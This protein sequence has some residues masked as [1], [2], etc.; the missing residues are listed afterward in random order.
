MC[1][2]TACRLNGKD[3]CKLVS[4]KMLINRNESWV[5][6]QMDNEILLNLGVAL[7][8]GLLIGAERERSKTN[9]QNGGA[10]NGNA[11]GDN[12]LAGIRTFTIASILGAITAWMNFWLLFATVICVAMFA[13]VAFYVRRDERLG[14]TTEVSLLFTIVLGALSM[15]APVLAAALAVFAAILLSAKAP[16]HGFVLGVLTKEEL[17]DFL[18]LAGATLIILPL[19]PN[20][21]MGPFEAINPSHLWTIVILVMTIG[22]LGHLALR[23]IGGRIGLPLVGLVSGFIS[24]I[25]TI[26]AMGHRARETPSLSGSAVAGAVLSSFSTILQMTLILTAISHPTL[27]ALAMPLIFGGL[28]ILVCGGVLT[29]NAMHQAVKDDDKLS[30]SFSVKTAFYMAGLIALVLVVSAALNHWFGQ[31]GLVLGSGL[32]GLVDAH[33]PVVSIASLVAN[34][35]ISLDN[36]ALPILAAFTCNAF[37]KAMVATAS[38]GKVFALQVVPSLLIQVIA[39]WVGWLLF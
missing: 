4:R 36:A 24:S 35:Q 26:S 8:I 1:E 27:N 25:A 7:G 6:S 32:V 11:Q 19:I 17:N 21:S 33:S 13:A 9:G 37:A 5:G 16:I 30:Q 3:C 18:I 23:M 38:G 2:I 34:Y 12:A 14:L 31:T 28:A 20:T 22:A 39:V 15:A 29:L 10:Q